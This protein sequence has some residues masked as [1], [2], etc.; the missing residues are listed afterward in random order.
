VGFDLVQHEG[1]E[2]AHVNQLQAAGGVAGCRHTAARGE[3][4][5]PPRQLAQVV[6]RPHD[7]TGA[8]DQGIVA[9]VGLLDRQFAPT[10]AGTQQVEIGRVPVFVRHARPGRGRL[11]HRC[12]APGPVDTRRRDERVERGRPGQC[13]RGAQHVHRDQPA[14]VDDRVE[15]TPDE[16]LHARIGGPV[17]AK[18]L[19]VLDV[20]DVA[21]GESAIERRDLVPAVDGVAHDG[22]SDERRAADDQQLHTHS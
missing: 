4:G 13:P 1:G 10:F 5:Q 9:P 7:R 12:G 21:A 17:A 22:A 14:R 16:R 11:V 19:D 3:P 2:I 8:R 20:L 18:H 6:V 15:T